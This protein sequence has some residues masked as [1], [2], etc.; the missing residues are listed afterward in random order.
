MPKGRLP[1]IQFAV[2]QRIGRGIV[3]DSEVRTGSRNSRGARLRC[4]CG[5]VYEAL[6]SSLVERNDGRINTTSCGCARRES[7]ARIGKQT[8]QQAQQVR[9]QERGLN[10][11]TAARPADYQR[12]ANMMARC[13]NPN[14]PKY[15][16]WGGRGIKVC[17]RWHNFS[18]F[19]E[20]ID[21]LL[22]PCPEGYTLD[23]I[24]PDFDYEPGKVRWATYSTQN[25]NRHKQEGAS[26]QYLGVS[27]DA[28]RGRWQAKIGVAGRTIPLGRFNSEEAAHQ[29]YQSALLSITDP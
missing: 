26:S 6:A 2:G 5:T 1:S 11:L 10:G 27:W 15:Q 18:V 20:D 22:G 25:R 12:W 3:V 13:Y 19:L 4:D 29:A 23:R 16:Y 7:S 28:S 24:E 17:E 9:W 14:Y 21:R 8:I